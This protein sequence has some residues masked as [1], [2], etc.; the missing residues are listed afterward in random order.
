MKRNLEYSISGRKI[1]WPIWGVIAICMVAS[2][3]T[4]LLTP[5]YGSPEGTVADGGWVLTTLAT[6][7]IAL[8]G[9]VAVYGLCLPLSKYTLEA[10]SIEGEKI[11]TDYDVAEYMKLVIVGSL[12]TIVTFGLYSPWFMVRITRYLLGNAY[13]RLR[14]LGFHAKGGDLFAIVVLGL[15]LP[16]VVLMVAVGLLV[17]NFGEGADPLFTVLGAVIF[18][19]VVVV[20]M[21]LFVVLVTRWA[22]NLSVGEERIVTTVPTGEAT[23]FVVGQILLCCITCGLYAPMMELRILQYFV[24]SCRVGEGRDARRFGMKIMAWRDWAFVWG[25]LLLVMFTFGIYTPWYYA[26]VMN[27][28]VPRIYLT[29]EK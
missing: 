24:D 21:A 2:L 1:M 7:A 16:L 28:F 25:Q 3:A 27:R 23:L 26:R 14:P 18:Y 5:D 29:P 20:W 15:L 4:L 13:L 19:L 22:I 11:T 12:L 8:L 6:V 9:S 17:V 10:L